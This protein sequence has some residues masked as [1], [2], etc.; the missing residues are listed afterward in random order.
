MNFLQALRSLGPIDLRG[1]RRDS[2]LS[3]MVFLPVL[4]ALVLR[5][6]VPA[7]TANLQDTYGFDLKPYYPVIL[8]YFVVVMCP[9][10]VSV[11]AGF[12]MLDEKDDQTLTGLQVTPLSLNT[13]IAYRVTVPFVLTVVMM[14]VVF[15][16]ANLSAFDP[17][18]I[19]ITAVAAAPMAPM[20]ALYLA[21]IAENKVQGFALMKLSGFI[22]FVPI[23]AYFVDSGW[24]AAFGIIPTYWPM[25]VYWLLQAGREPVW[26]YVLAAVVYQSL[27][28]AVFIR[29]FDKVLHR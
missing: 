8:A 11:L 24:E 12:L 17:R 7:L 25:K 3:W 22:L 16:L 5:W 19:L 4:S 26:P 13:Y 23:F 29:R 9:L 18:L 20:F 10:I 27:V 6:G 2:A 15:P 21:S 28:T 1:I 14:F